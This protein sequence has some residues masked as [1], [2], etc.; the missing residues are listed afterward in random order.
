MRTL[1]IAAAGLLASSLV[2]VAV[3]QTVFTSCAPGVDAGAVA[4]AC[5]KTSV[6]VICIDN[7][8]YNPPVTMVHTGE[9]VAWVNVENACSSVNPPSGCD[10][11]HQVVTTGGTGD[12][13]N[14]GPIC[15][16]NRGTTGLLVS[17]PPLTNNCADD[18][19]ANP[20]LPPP[21]NVFCHTFLGAGIQHYTCFTNPGHTV[22]LH[23]LIDV[24]SPSGPPY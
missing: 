14:S 1:T 13:I 4:A 3:A 23:G 5:G 19:A 6:Q 12:S 24:E 18:A 9:T 15:S 22:L 17:G 20:L 8:Q 11:H 10:T 2:S 21:T 7:F 16:P